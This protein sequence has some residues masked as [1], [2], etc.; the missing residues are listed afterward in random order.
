MNI[1]PQDI[2]T[3]RVLFDAGNMVPPPFHYTYQLQVNFAGEDTTVSYEVRYLH[4]EELSEE[5]ILDEGFTLNDDWSWT[6][7]LPLN[8]KNALLNQIEKQSW[9]KKPEKV[10][11]GEA[12][13][14]ISLIGEEEK[15]LFEGKPAD[16][17]A[18]EYFLQE[19][20]QAIYELAQKEAP[21]E[22]V[23]R[24]VK[25]G[26]EIYEIALK[27]SFAERIIWAR[28]I[29]DG[30]EVNRIQPDWK[31]LKNLMK[32][33][34]IPDYDYESARE[35]APKK[36]GKYIFTGE[37]LW[38]KFGESLT[39]PDQKSNSLERLEASLKDLFRG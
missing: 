7:K 11:E 20:I 33:I 27:A 31:I 34:Y 8:W 17:A 4:R 12:G 2:R 19:L 36:R 23:Y 1:D 26:N 25:K 37:G 13:L 32:N 10:T 21:F 6:G 9:P 38:F 24:E 18:W 15:P 14:L 30:Q 28:E 39:E 22:L 35:Q 16:I 3:F 5:E 29:Q